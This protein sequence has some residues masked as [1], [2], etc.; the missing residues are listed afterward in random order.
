MVQVI[1]G[2]LQALLSKPEAPG[3]FKIL[4]QGRCNFW[5]TD[6]RL[7]LRKEKNLLKS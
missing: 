7:N 1:Q 2:L 4:Q 5:D 3:I 6:P